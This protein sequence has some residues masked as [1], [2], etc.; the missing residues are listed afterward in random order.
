MTDKWE[1]AESVAKNAAGEYRA[2]IG[3]EWV[4]VEKA[5]KSASGEYRIERGTIQQESEPESSLVTDVGRD[6]L[7]GA[8][9]GTAQLGS[10][11][12]APIDWA[13]RK[14]GVQ[15]DALFPKDRRAA[16]KSALSEGTAIPGMP[17]ADTESMAFQAG[18]IGAEIAGT[19]GAGGAI[20]KGLKFAPQLAA[21]VKS[22][23]FQLAKPA[24]NALSGL[25][26]RA[27]GGA[28]SGGAMAGMVN[29]QDATTGAALGAALPAA[30]KG[31]GK[32]GNAL[33]K[34]AT[35]EVAALAQKAHKL[36]IEIPADRL[37]DSKTLNAMSASLNYVPFSGR[38]TTEEKMVSQINRAVSR[39]F[40][41]D[42]DNITAALRKASD[43]LGGKFDEV[44]KNNV[45]KVD[46]EFLSA[47]VKHGDDAAKE[48]ESGQAKIIHNQIDEILAKAEN[49]VID[50]QA[51]YNIKKT[52]DK[53]GKRNSAESFYAN[54][55]R[56]SL[57]DAL[58]K[59]I[60]PHEAAKFAKVRQ[61]YGNM[62]TLE[63]L[64]PAGAE[65]EISMGRLANIR[66]ARDPQLRDVVDIA[67]Q[68]GRTRESPHGAAQR[69]VLGA[70]APVAAAT[71]QIPVYLSGMAA[72]RAANTALNSQ[73]VRNAMLQNP[74]QANKLLQALQSQTGRAAIIQSSP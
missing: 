72:G 45:V 11:I 47:L 67:A 69:V 50:G 52:L 74:Q 22:G 54:D 32:L 8:V 5:Q 59:S 41:Q 58:N 40:G 30:V 73:I 51:A 70:L 60:G 34:K 3:G 18:Q 27:A 44:L 19:A 7:A 25:A 57:M 38:A 13:A 55:L 28:I 62:L 12:L 24:T 36:G 68:F 4:P 39:T 31:A 49:G 48:L 64:A 17:A 16:I 21:A 20:A 46:D 65:G 15:N 26:T 37:V 66:N 14:L 43:D 56:L 63:K 23:G 9:S 42:S 10:T 29:P 53:I 71:G 2:L 61:Q 1:P 33:V 6:A 35:P